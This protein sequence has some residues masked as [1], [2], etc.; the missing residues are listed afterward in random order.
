MGD[1]H[2]AAKAREAGVEEMDEKPPVSKKC[3]LFLVFILLSGGIIA[4]VSVLKSGKSAELEEELTTTTAK[5]TTVPIA[6]LTDE[7]EILARC[8]NTFSAKLGKSS[9]GTL[10]S[11]I[12]NDKK[13]A[14][15]KGAF[16]LRGIPSE[17]KASF[18]QIKIMA[19]KGQIPTV[20]VQ[21]RPAGYKLILDQDELV[22]YDGDE[23]I[24]DWDAYDLKLKEYIKALKEFPAL[25]ILEP[26]LL[27]LTFN[28]KNLQYG[29]ENGI[30]MNEFLKRAQQ[31]TNALKKAWVYIDAGDPNW[32][33]EE[34][35]L[36]H[37]AITL[38]RLQGIR[39][40]AMNTAFFANMTYTKTI[41][42]K[43]SCKTNLQFVVDTGR[44]GGDFSFGKEIEEMARCRYDPPD[45]KAGNRPMWGFKPTKEASGRRRR[46]IYDTHYGQPVAPVQPRGWSNGFHTDLDRKT[47]AE[48][49]PMAGRPILKNTNVGTQKP[50]ARSRGTSRIFANNMRTGPAPVGS[51]GAG[52]PKT[53]GGKIGGGSVISEEQAE[54]KMNQIAFR[55][56][57]TGCLKSNV[58]MT[59]HDA[60]VWAR[61]AGESDGR[62]LTKGTLDPCLLKHA[63]ACDGECGLIL[64]QPC[65]CQGMP[66]Q[67][68][69]SHY[70]NPYG[71]GYPAFPSYHQ[72]SYQNPFGR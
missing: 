64:S 32:L 28:V 5:P 52:S 2:H 27:Q 56:R 40:F 70:G 67:S 33:S 23:M 60:Y 57:K 3:F 62:V 42:R 10:P 55:S 45:I 25:V 1:P 36:E 72:P 7:T 44:N 16:W 20:V 51:K 66:Q 9:L 22:H 15:E 29:Y 63:L 13:K 14:L 8:K 47:L 46:G 38:L 35:H 65:T 48:I 26:K 43:I 30:Y 41:A 19:C 54:D 4:I 17:D 11:S 6:K 69:P 49:G 53:G 21:I 71:A 61:A 12:L 59:F 58:M 37:T 31:T 68:P 50:A 18:K 39:G 34:D 24:E